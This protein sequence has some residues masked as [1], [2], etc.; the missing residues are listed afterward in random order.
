MKYSVQHHRLIRHFVA[1]FTILALSPICQ[2]QILE[3]KTHEI[4]GNNYL[5][6]TADITQNEIDRYLFGAQGSS[7]WVRYERLNIEGEVIWNIACRITTDPFWNRLIYSNY[8]D[9]IKSY[10]DNPGD[11]QLN[12]PNGL[13]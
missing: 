10:G 9:F 7:I 4:A 5:R 11:L 6:L 13:C 2:A 3:Q 8:D 1:Y 12:F